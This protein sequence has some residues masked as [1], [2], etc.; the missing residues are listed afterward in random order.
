MVI[1]DDD[2]GDDVDGDHSATIVADNDLPVN[3][4]GL[5]LWSTIMCIIHLKRPLLPGVNRI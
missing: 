4:P 1:G 2:G 3:T 5:P